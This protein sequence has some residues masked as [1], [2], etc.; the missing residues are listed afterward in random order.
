MEHW[1]NSVRPC[2]SIRPRRWCVD[3]ITAHIVLCAS[4]SQDPVG[5]AW[6]AP[7]DT[8]VSVAGRVADAHPSDL[9][10]VT[11]ELSHVASPE[12]GDFLLALGEIGPVP[13]SESGSVV[14]VAYAVVEGTPQNASLHQRGDPE[15]PGYV[16]PRRWLSMFGGEAIS[17]ETGSGREDLAEWITQHPLFA[18]VMINRIWQGHFSHGLSTTPN[19]FGSRGNRPA[20]L[21][22]LNWLAAQFQTHDYSIKAMHRLILNSRAYQRSCRQEMAL[23]EENVN[24]RY[25]SRFERRRLTAEEIRDSLLFVSRRLDLSI[26]GAHPF[27]PESS[28]KFTQHDPFNAVYESNRRSAFLMVQRQRR[29]PYLALFDGADPNSSTATR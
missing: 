28:W 29:H 26:D 19:D 8:V 5:I 23:I 21:Q 27:P 4:W 20:Q 2:E 14:P 15:K 16:V 17:M 11:F 3:E 13:G 10:G 1:R 22:L 25:L 9:D 7:V 12:A 6:I 18:R 24:N